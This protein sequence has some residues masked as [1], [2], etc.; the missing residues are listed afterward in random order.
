VSYPIAESR[1]DSAILEN[2]TVTA[3]HSSKSREPL[4]G[5]STGCRGNVKGKSRYSCVSPKTRRVSRSRGR[6]PL[7][8]FPHRHVV[9]ATANYGQAS[10]WPRQI[11]LT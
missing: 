5:Q 9:A 2:P 11:L 3:I 1:R 4:M 10:H 8:A 6:R 7:I